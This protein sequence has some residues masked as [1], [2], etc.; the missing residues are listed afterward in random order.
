[1]DSGRNQI[2]QLLSQK[3]LNF[4][5]IVEG[6]DGT[7]IEAREKLKEMLGRGELSYENFVF[8]LKEKARGLEIEKVMK[9]YAE[10][11]KKMPEPKLEFFQGQV[12]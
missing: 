10:I 1:M 6:C 2:V 4:W 5:E 3:D 7:V 11:A 8:S 12:S 9:Q